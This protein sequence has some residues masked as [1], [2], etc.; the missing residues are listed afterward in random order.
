MRL[1][2]IGSFIDLQPYLLKVALGLI[3]YLLPR[4]YLMDFPLAS[5]SFKI[6]CPITAIRDRHSK[7][8]LQSG[9]VLSRNVTVNLLITMYIRKRNKIVDI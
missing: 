4:I 8:E 2:E 1:C 6:K 3:T 5:C 9:G 7:L